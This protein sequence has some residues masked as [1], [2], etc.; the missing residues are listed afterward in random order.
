MM[1]TR[2]WVVVAILVVAVPVVP[3]CATRQVRLQMTREITLIPPVISDLKLD[4][5]GQVDTRGQGRTVAVTLRGDPEL[6]ATFDL[7]GGLQ[8]QE[9][10]ET[11]PGV[12]VGSFQIRP[13]ETGRVDVVAHLLHSPTGSKQ[14]ISRDGVLVLVAPEDQQAECAPAMV[15]EFEEQLRGLTVLFEFNRYDVTAGAQEVLTNARTILESHP[16]CVIHVSGYA[17]EVGSEEYNSTLSAVRAGEVATFI[18]Q[19][20]GIPAERV[21]VHWHGE[22]HPVDT[23][24]MAAGM[25]RNRRVELRAQG[26]D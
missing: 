2:A 3:A 9:M 4:P 5:S 7:K 8:G 25:A 19:S 20:L 24:G 11:E 15:A 16:G 26:A 1:G 10:K 22:S 17:D 14:D 23:S 12:Y 21:A 13:N 18:E 6:Q